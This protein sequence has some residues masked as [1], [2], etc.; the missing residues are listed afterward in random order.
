MEEVLHQSHRSEITLVMVVALEA[1]VVMKKDP[2]LGGRT[3]RRE[4]S[5]YLPS[6]TVEVSQTKHINAIN[7]LWK[8]LT[9]SP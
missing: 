7:S 1:V 2:P 4:A 5:A 8:Q 9:F 6:S 3:G